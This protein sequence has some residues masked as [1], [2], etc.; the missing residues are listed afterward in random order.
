MFMGFELPVFMI[1]ISLVLFLIL[2]PYQP[3]HFD[4]THNPAR[5][6]FFLKLVINIL[7]NCPTHK[8]Y[9]K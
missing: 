2:L 7:A 4:L 3:Y 9:K 5:L 8:I 1:D 6:D